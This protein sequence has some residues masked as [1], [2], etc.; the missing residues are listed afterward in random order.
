MTSSSISRVQGSFRA[1]R[2]WMTE[3]EVESSHFFYSGSLTY[4]GKNIKI[5]NHRCDAR[6]EIYLLGCNEG[7]NWVIAK[8]PLKVT[9]RDLSVLRLLTTDNGEPI[10]RNYRD[11]QDLGHR[12]VFDVVNDGT[13]GFHIVNYV[14]LQTM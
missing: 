10:L 11:P 13:G 5:L 6:F 7:V 14:H 3:S 9:P 4:P 12:T 2:Y 8:T 1:H